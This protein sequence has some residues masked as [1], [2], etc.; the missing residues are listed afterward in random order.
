MLSLTSRLFV[1]PKGKI[2]FEQHRQSIS[3]LLAN[4]SKVEILR[5]EVR[6]PGIFYEI[7]VTVS[8]ED[9]AES[10]VMRSIGIFENGKMIRVEPQEQGANYNDLFGDP[11][12][13][14][15]K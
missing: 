9:D 8:N 2:C 11:D 12:P 1:T 6:D 13:V 14:E 7:C 10:M 4:R 3:K 15:A 5:M